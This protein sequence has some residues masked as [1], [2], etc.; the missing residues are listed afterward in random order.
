MIPEYVFLAFVAM[1]LSQL[2]S[3]W[4][5]GASSA[6]QEQLHLTADIRPILLSECVKSWCMLSVAS[7]GMCVGEDR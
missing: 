2:G 3:W 5:R 1:D 7:D 6:V 4:P